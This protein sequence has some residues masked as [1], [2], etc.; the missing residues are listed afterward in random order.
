MGAEFQVDYGQGGDVKEVYREVRDQAAWEYGHGGY[1]G[2]I[3]ESTGV[4]MFHTAEM[5]REEAEALAY[6]SMDAAEKWG[7]ALAIP[8]PGGFVFFG[9]YSS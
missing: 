3:A 1:T 8:V 6:E 7:P 4:V 5:P 2:T 9:W